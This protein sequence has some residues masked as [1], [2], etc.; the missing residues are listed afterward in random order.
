ME[1]NRLRDKEQPEEG[2]EVV[3]LVQA[4]KLEANE[5]G[6][7][8]S[9]TEAKRCRKGPMASM[10]RTITAGFATLACVLTAVSCSPPVKT[11]LDLKSL[12]TIK[13]DQAHQINHDTHKN[14]I[15]EVPAG[16]GFVLDTSEYKKEYA[17]A[18]SSTEFVLV[19]NVIRLDQVASTH[20]GIESVDLAPGRDLYQVCPDSG[21]RSGDKFIVQIAEEVTGG[22]HYNLYSRWSAYVRVK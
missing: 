22:G 10:A 19:S 18:P 21:L 15:Y 13:A 16:K 3:A 8:A 14:L 17:Q 20:A 2:Q 9:E 6:I 11:N 12:P 4:R 1:G 7:I 5:H